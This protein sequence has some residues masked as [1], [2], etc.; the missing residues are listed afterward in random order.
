VVFIM[1]GKSD[2]RAHICKRFGHVHQKDSEHL[3][4][5]LQRYTNKH[6]GDR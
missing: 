2:N 6:G 4:D 3:K 1:Y 5:I